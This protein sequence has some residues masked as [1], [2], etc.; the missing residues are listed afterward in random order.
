M[1]PVRTIARP[2][3]VAGL[4]YPDDPA[5]LQRDVRRYLDDASPPHHTDP[6]PKAIIGPHAGYAYSGPVAGSAYAPLESLR[7]TTQRVVIMS[8]A[9]RVAFSD[10]ALPSVGAFDTPLGPIVLDR[11]AMETILSLPSVVSL[12]EPHA[13]EHGIEVHLPFILETLGD[14]KIVPIVFGDVSYHPAARVF[15]ALW[16]G[17][18]TLIVVSSDLSH[19]HDHPTATGLDRATADAIVERRLDHIG[20]D[21]ACGSVAIRGLLAAE[22]GR[23][24]TVRCTDLR[25]SGDT[26]GDRDRVVGYGAFALN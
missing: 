26:S 2:T 1:A 22:P 5:T 7:G 6:P 10:L 8:P 3:A 12:D 17:D 16:G 18:E 15:E 23:A 14:V 25:N 4:F 13:P 20:P 21:E 9:H 24:L 11:E 19:F